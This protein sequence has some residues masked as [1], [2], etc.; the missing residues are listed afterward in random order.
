MY[1]GK[2]IIL[3]RTIHVDSISTRRRTIGLSSLVMLLLVLLDL[4]RSAL[5]LVIELLILRLDL[6][7]AVLRVGAAATG[8]VLS[9]DFCHIYLECAFEAGQ[10]HVS[11]TL[12]RR[13]GYL[14]SSKVEW[15]YS[16]R[17]V[18]MRS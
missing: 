3:I 13:G 18:F 6:G 17:A 5:A 9:L 11:S 16:L 15:W 7:L 14:P 2:L 4:L 1:T 8:T 12:I 10:T